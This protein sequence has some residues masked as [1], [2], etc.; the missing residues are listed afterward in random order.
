MQPDTPMIS[1]ARES[2]LPDI[3]R[4]YSVLYEKDPDLSKMQNTFR[5]MSDDKKYILLAA[6]VR[7][8]VIGTIMGIVCLDMSEDSAPFLLIENFIVSAQNRHEGI[9]GMLMEALEREAKLKQ[10][11]IAMLQSRKERKIAHKAY[12]KYGFS[13]SETIAFRKFLY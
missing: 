13:N 2:D 4:L 3:A 7:G 9:G 1:R 5:E 8:E 10:C 12:E 6:K 11:Q